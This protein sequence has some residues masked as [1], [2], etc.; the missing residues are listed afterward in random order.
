MEMAAV[1]L[2]KPASYGEGVVMICIFLSSR[3]LSTFHVCLCWIFT[4]HYFIVEFGNYF[5]LLVPIWTIKCVG[6][7]ICHLFFVTR[8][9]T[10]SNKNKVACS[11]IA[12]MELA[13]VG[14][15]QHCS[16]QAT[17]WTELTGIPANKSNGL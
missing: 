15:R 9:W 1:S 17:Y 3:T 4:Y 10:L 2:S 14:S 7:F 5:A 6:E 16:F 12:L 11:M 8:I 13:H